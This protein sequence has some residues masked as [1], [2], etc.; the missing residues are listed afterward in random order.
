M[1]APVGTIIVSLISFRL[2]RG[3]AESEW[4]GDVGQTPCAKIL[5]VAPVSTLSHVFVY[6]EFAAGLAQRCHHVDLLVPQK[7]SAHVKTPNIQQ[8]TSPAFKQLSDELFWYHLNEM[9][10]YNYVAGTIV[11][12]WYLSHAPRVCERLLQDDVFREYLNKPDEEYD[13]VLISPHIVDDC[14][15][16]FAHKARRAGKPWGHIF[17]SMLMPWVGHAFGNPGLG[18]YKPSAMTTWSTEMTYFQQ[19]VSQITYIFVMNFRHLWSYPRVRK[20]LIEGWDSDVPNLADLESTSVISFNNEDL[21]VF[22][23]QEPRV[24]DIIDIGGAHCRPAKELPKELR[25]WADS[26]TEGFILFA[27]GSALKSENF[28]EDAREMFVEAFKRFPE[29]HFLWKWDHGSMSGLSDNVKLAKWLPQQD[30][31]GHKN[32][33]GFMTHGGMLST[34][35]ATYHGVPVIG[36]PIAADQHT[37]MAKVTGVDSAGVVLHWGLLTVDD[38]VSAVRRILQDEKILGSVKRRSRLFR[39]QPMTPLERGVFWTE[40]VLRNGYDTGLRSPTRNLSWFEMYSVHVF[41]GLILLFVF[42]FVVFVFCLIRLKN[43]L[44]ASKERVSNER[45]SRNKRD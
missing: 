45:K 18:S 36:L 32:I 35:E 1:K 20:A 44:F 10:S 31:L 11:F 40:Y 30:L 38:I 21:R 23:H 34:Q 6:S 41:M 17:S 28:P 3:F 29:I 8:I 25:D 27:L 19:A 5:I 37:N 2:C 13:L 12:L 4:H 42:F 22:T 7:A 24:A 9:P 39:D 16:A 15:L 33:R 26:K 43:A 14:A